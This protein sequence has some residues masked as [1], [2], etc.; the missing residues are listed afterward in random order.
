MVKKKFV[1]IAA[2]LA[3][4]LALMLMPMASPVIADEGTGTG[5]FGANNVAPTV[6]TPTVTTMTP[7]TDEWV[8]V[9]VTDN[10]LLSDLTT[11]ETVLFYNAAGYSDP[12]ASPANDNQTLIVMTWYATND[13][14]V[15]HANAGST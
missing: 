11:V 7:Q 8:N 2:T 14:F 12:G 9:T 13:T 1:S 4:V 5:T 3:M 10:N 6:A 15:S